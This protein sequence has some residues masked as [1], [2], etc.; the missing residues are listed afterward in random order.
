MPV[1]DALKMKSPAFRRRMSRYQLDIE[2]D[3]EAVELIGISC[4]G[5]DYT[6][7]WAINK[8][9]GLALEREEK[10]LECCRPNG[11][12]STHVI[13]KHYDQ[14]DRI[15]YSLIGNRGENGFLIPERKEVDFLLMMEGEQVPVNELLREVRALPQVLTTFSMDPEGLASLENL[16]H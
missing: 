7:C 8:K 9:T 14:E 6:L 15:S 5:R 3:D 16:F 2:Y 1:A 11:A 10:D 4:H 12:Q 13:F